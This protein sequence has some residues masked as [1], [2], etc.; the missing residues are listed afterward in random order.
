MQLSGLQPLAL[1]LTACATVGVTALAGCGGRDEELAS[2]RDQPSATNGTQ[3]APPQN[4]IEIADTLREFR[5]RYESRNVSACD[6]TTSKFKAAISSPSCDIAVKQHRLDYAVVTL[7][8]VGNRAGKRKATVLATV[9]RDKPPRIGKGE[10]TEEG[11][12]RL[13]KEGIAWRI[14]GIRLGTGS[15]QQGRVP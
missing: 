3:A 5:S 2:P 13:T 12:V 15:Q 7:S 6:L 1:A 11:R 9:R 14:D 10:A 8:R 4:P